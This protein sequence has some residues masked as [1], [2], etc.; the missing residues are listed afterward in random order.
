MTV[1]RDPRIVRRDPMTVHRHP[2]TVPRD[3]N[4]IPRDPRTFPMDPRRARFPEPSAQHQSSVHPKSLAS[5]Y[6][7]YFIL[8]IFLHRYVVIFI[9]FVFIV[10]QFIFT[11]FDTIFLA[12]TLEY[13]T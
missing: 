12:F 7:N 9:V 1:P 8:W 11:R 6:N 4:S 10:E 13:N 3:P 5:S 2:M